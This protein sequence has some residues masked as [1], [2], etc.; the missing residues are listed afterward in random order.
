MVIAEWV[1]R[2]VKVRSVT[3]SDV[4]LCMCDY[5]CDCGC[6]D[7]HHHDDDD[8]ITCYVKT[9]HLEHLQQQQQ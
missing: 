9:E 2:N 5:D 1:W 7:Q 6:Y 8:M 4:L 3:I